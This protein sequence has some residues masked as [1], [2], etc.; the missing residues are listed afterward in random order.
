MNE[1]SAC[2]ITSTSAF[3]IATTSYC[4]AATL[5]SPYVSAT[6]QLGADDPYRLPRNVVPSR[7][8]LVLEPDLA[9]ATFTGTVAVELT[10]TETTSTMLLN[11]AELKINEAHA[12]VGDEQID[13]TWA[14]D[15]PNDRLTVTTARP[16]EMG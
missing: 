4:T 1:S 14:L 12:T 2:A 16:R 3:P 13:V 8:S 6:N 15:E 10:V 11:A 7:Y 5:L 9:E